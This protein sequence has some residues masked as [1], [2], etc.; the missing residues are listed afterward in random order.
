MSAPTP[1]TP[2]SPLV[3]AI[4]MTLFCSSAYL[5]W[6]VARRRFVAATGVNDETSVEAES[7]SS[8]GATAPLPPRKVALWGLIDLIFTVLLLS[9]AM[10][11]GFTWLKGRVELPPRVPLH[12]L[13]SSV[14]TQLVWVNSLAMLLATFGGLLFIHMRTFAT[15]AELGWSPRD[16]WSDL[17]L[18]ARTFVLWSG[19]ILTLQILLTIWFPYHHPLMDTVKKSPEWSVL[20]ANAVAGVV[21]APICE[22]L[23]FRLL[24]LGWLENIGERGL[25]ARDWLV[26]P[27]GERRQLVRSRQSWLPI[28]TS[29]ALFAAAHASQGPAPIPLFIL[30]LVLGRLYQTTGR[31]LPGIVVHFLLNAWSFGLLLLQIM[32][33]GST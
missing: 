20:L 1:E 26:G 5:W 16:R 32:L 18:G 15:A 7:C 14:A 10:S 30:A 24:L 3:A 9:M 8:A 27:A 29:S 4:V 23:L 2:G 13:P 22:E 25:L 31:V 12:E 11:A 6:Q 28:V 21:V 33:K 17:K 19:P